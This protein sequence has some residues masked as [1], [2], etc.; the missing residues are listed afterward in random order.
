MYDLII[1]RKD[2]YTLAAKYCKSE[3]INTELLIKALESA[4]KC[5]K[6]ANGYKENGVVDKANLPINLSPEVLFGLNT[7]EKSA[8]F[9]EIIAV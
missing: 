8:K 6:V 5:A 4:E 1:A 9:D 2:K 7:S 3:L